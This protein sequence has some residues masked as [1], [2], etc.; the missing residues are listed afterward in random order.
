MADVLL[1]IGTEEIPA[2]FMTRMLSELKKGAEEQLQNNRLDFEQLRVFGTDRRLALIINGLAEKQPDLD[3]ELKGPPANIAIKDGKLTQ[4]G[5]GFCKKNNLDPNV[6][7]Q[8]E[9]DGRSYLFAKVFQKGKTAKELLSF[10]SKELGSFKIGESP[11]GK[12]IFESILSELHLPIAMKWGEL[13]LQFIRPVH[14]IVA[15]YNNE[16]LSFEFAGISA[17]NHSM[18][19]RFFSNRQI[20]ITSPGDYRQIMEDN[21]VLVDHDLRKDTIISQIKIIE[22][23]HKLAAVYDEALLTELT[24]LN[25]YPLALVAEID[26]KYLKVPQECLILTMQKNQKYIPL[27]DKKD[28]LT[29]YFILIT[30]NFND[31]SV[32]NIIKGNIKVVTARLEDARFFYEE[33]LK[34][35]MDDWVS[36]LAHVTYIEKIGSVKEKVDRIIKNSE[37]LAKKLKLSKEDQKNAVRAAQICK[38]DL[39]SKM[40]YE[41]PE[42]QGVMGKY[43]ASAAGEPEIV[44]EAMLDHWKPRFAGEN[45]SNISNISAVVAIADKIDSITGCYTAG[46]IPTSSSDPYALRRAAQGIVNIID[47]KD[48]RFNIEDLMD[49]SLSLQKNS[50]ANLKAEIIKLFFS[51]LKYLLQERNV[52]YDVINAIIQVHSET[53]LSDLLKSIIIAEVLNKNKKNIT[54]VIEAAVRIHNIVAGERGF[55]PEV[56]DNYI[57]KKATEYEKTLFKSY[58]LTAKELAKA[59]KAEDYEQA[60]LSL[61]KL[62]KP[63]NDLFDNVMVNDQD[64]EVRAQRLTLLNQVE[65]LYLQIA[66]FSQLVYK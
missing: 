56:D 44:A 15:L 16:P 18:G 19:H 60:L 8:K 41:F 50:N 34:T 28:K 43:Y 26:E 31:K 32:Q 10:Q 33:D 14:W 6:V 36:S 49:H 21:N 58:Q 42:L 38:A 22:N 51:R 46:L 3:N 57:S 40:V 2:R 1:E 4:A 66:D 55:K 52:G 27:V 29:K 54:P 20:E 25:E 63:V 65:S 24:F 61:D 47:S 30:N 39:E 5:L 64:K 45:I 11:I 12:S 62:T 37:W 17:G 7:S 9:F 48:L 23:D 53:S 59:F 35:K 13:D